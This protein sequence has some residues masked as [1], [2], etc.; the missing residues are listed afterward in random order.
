[1]PL[2]EAACKDYLL[3]LKLRPPQLSQLIQLFDR[4]DYTDVLSKTLKKLCNKLWLPKVTGIIANVVQQL[5]QHG[6]DRVK[7]VRE[8]LQADSCGKLCQLQV[9]FC[10]LYDRSNDFAPF[11]HLTETSLTA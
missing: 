6:D 3:S 10:S 5:V 1:M 2:L 11:G 7:T 8:A 4:L 9:R